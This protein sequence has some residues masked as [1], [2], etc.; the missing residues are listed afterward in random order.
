MVNGEFPLFL[1]KGKQI[2]D[3]LFINELRMNHCLV[4]QK[5]SIERKM[6]TSGIFWNNIKKYFKAIKHFQARSGKIYELVDLLQRHTF[7][8]LQLSQL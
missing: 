4:E 7:P 3:T 1:G 2:K 8:G 5:L 6:Q